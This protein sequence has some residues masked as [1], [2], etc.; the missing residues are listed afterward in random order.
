MWYVHSK[1][2]PKFDRYTLAKNIFDNLLEI[3]T[4]IKRAEFAN[5]NFKIAILTNVSQKLD[6]V[7]ILIRLTNTLQII[8][9]EKY[10]TLEDELVQIGNMLGGWIKYLNNTRA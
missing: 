10:I 9:D 3:T 7:K 5:K 4:Q 1:K 6:T 2:F 8:N